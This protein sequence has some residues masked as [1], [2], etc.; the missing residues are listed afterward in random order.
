VICTL[1]GI[2]TKIR[3]I[4]LV[5]HL[6]RIVETINSHKIMARNPEEK[7]PFGTNEHRSEDNTVVY[8]AVAR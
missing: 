6:A 4:K 2:S 3:I 5:G 1:L 8:R 7:K